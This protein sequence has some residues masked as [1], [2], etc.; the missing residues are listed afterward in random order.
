[1][2]LVLRYLYLITCYV[3]FPSTLCARPYQMPGPS[4]NTEVHI[5]FSSRDFSVTFMILWTCSVVECLLRKPNWWVGIKFFSFIIGLSLFKSS[6]SKTFDIVGLY[7]EIVC[8]SLPGLGSIIISAT[9]HISGTYFMKKVALMRLVSLTNLF[10][11]SCFS[12]APLIKS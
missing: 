9:L 1:M 8:D 6:F 12:T 5:F 7:D 3:V 10:L 11:D 4:R 2:T